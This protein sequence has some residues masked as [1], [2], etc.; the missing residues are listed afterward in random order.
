MI[1]ELPAGWTYRLPQWIEYGA[2]KE[3]YEGIGLAPNIVVPATEAD[4]IA[5]RDVQLERAVQLA[6]AGSAQAA[7][8]GSA[9]SAGR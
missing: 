6:Q 1:R 4:S 9:R 2:Q 5:G 3:S 7:E 8:P